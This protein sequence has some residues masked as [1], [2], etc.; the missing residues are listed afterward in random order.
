MVKN[1]EKISLWRDN[2]EKTNGINLV[3][4]DFKLPVTWTILSIDDLKQII[5]C[6]IEGKEEKY[7]KER[8]YQDRDMLW[9]EMEYIFKTL[10]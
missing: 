6:W 1:I 2:K 5:K 7:P 4:I 3:R 8:G 9:S 10:R